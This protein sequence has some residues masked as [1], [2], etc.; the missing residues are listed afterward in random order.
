MDSIH[1]IMDRFGPQLERSTFVNHIR[2]G[3]E[4]RND[5]Y[6]FKKG[7]IRVYFIL[8]KPDVLILLG[9][10]KNSQDSDTAY[11]FRHFNNLPKNIPDYEP[12]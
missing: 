10:Y 8:Q 12:Q 6:E 7:N 3:K 2:G 9:G 4:D 5:V 1:A 11:I